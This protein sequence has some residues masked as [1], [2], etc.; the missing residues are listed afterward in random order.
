MK[1]GRERRAHERFDQTFT[2]ETG[3][4]DDGR[5]VKLIAN[6]LSLGGVH[7]TSDVGFQEM[8]R[9][10]VRLELPTPT[11][12]PTDSSAMSALDLEAIVVR[13]EEVTLPDGNN[14]FELALL[15]N[16]LGD[17]QRK[18]LARYLER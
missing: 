18:R 8:S 6:N 3:E 1:D 11:T 15:F 10:A 16:N 4:L 13:T 5:K 12:T 7:C 17:E 14:K 9:L 2:F